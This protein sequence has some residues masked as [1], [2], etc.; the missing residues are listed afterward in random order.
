MHILGKLPKGDFILHPLI[1][2]YFCSEVREIRWKGSRAKKIIE[3]KD[4]FVFRKMRVIL[5]KLELLDI[6]NKPKVY[7]RLQKY[8]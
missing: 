1:L 2:R 8:V 4:A 3:N 5:S 7:K 6:K